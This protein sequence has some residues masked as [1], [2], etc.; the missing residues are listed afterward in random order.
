M[1]EVLVEESGHIMYMLPK[2]HC[3]FNPIERVWVQAQRY[4]QASCKYNFRSHRNT[5]NPALDSVTKENVENHFR[6][7]RHYMFAYLEGVPG[8]SD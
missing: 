1:M 5:I 8:G 4:A 7:V 2:F 3:E 6:K